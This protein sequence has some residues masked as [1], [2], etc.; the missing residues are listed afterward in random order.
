MMLSLSFSFFSTI[1]CNVFKTISR[2]FRKKQL[3]SYEEANVWI[4]STDS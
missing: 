4:I 1:F 2:E 3:A